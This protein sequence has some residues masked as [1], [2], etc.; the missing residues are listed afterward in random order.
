ME[1]KTYPQTPLE[2]GSLE[3]ATVTRGTDSPGFLV[4]IMVRAMNG[5][6]GGH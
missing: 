1:V 5:V 4:L 2:N 3:G 6:V